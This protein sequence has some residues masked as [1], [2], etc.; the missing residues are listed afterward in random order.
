MSVCLDSWAILAWLDGEEPA[1]SRVGGLIESR[2]IVSWVNLVEVYYRVES[3]QPWMAVSKSGTAVYVPGNADKRSLVW[4]DR[5]GNVTP[6]S[7]EQCAFW[8]AALSPATRIELPVAAGARL[9]SCDRRDCR[10]LR[11]PREQSGENL[12]KPRWCSRGRRR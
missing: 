6:A 1:L 12:V 7:R 8:Q 3:L 11:R 10:L 4:V 5:A 2:P 9:L